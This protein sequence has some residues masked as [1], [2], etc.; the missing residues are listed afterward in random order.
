MKHVVGFLQEFYE[1]M[2][3]HRKLTWI[4]SLGNCNLKGNFDTKPIELIITTTQAALLL[5]FNEGTA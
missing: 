4:Y 1:A 3:K 5:L 2:V